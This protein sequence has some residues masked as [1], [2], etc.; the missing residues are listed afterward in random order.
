MSLCANYQNSSRLWKPFPG[1]VFF[2]NSARIFDFAYVPPGDFVSPRTGKI[3]AATPMGRFGE[4]EE[5]LGTLLYLLNNDAASFVTGVVIP[6]D[7]GVSAYA[8]V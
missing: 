2:T 8:G 4:P 3:M 5:L 6:V 7:G 1:R